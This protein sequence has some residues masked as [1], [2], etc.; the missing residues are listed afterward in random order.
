MEVYMSKSA[1]PIWRRLSYFGKAEKLDEQYQR[2]PI[3]RRSEQYYR[4]RWQ[5]DKTVRTTHVGNCNGSCSW[6]VHVKDDI[7]DWVTHQTDYPCT[8]TDMTKYEQSSCQRGATFLY[9]TYSPHRIR[10]PYIRTS[11]LTLRVQA[12]QEEKDPVKAWKSIVTAPEKSKQCKAARGKAGFVR[13]SW[14]EI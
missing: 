11:L 8:G 3:D 1:I 2:S 9:Y 10:Y 12:L 5:H 6:K 4:E 13:S 14:E 7:I